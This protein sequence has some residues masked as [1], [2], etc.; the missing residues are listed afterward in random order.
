[1]EAEDYAV[2]AAEKVKEIQGEAADLLL[3]IRRAADIESQQIEEQRLDF[4]QR[5]VEK[6]KELQA[7]VI[8]VR[9]LTD[10]RVHKIEEEMLQ[11]QAQIEEEVLQKSAERREALKSVTEDVESLSALAD[12]EYQ[13][14]LEKEKEIHEETRKVMLDMDNQR[15]RKVEEIEQSCQMWVTAFNQRPGSCKILVTKSLT[16]NDPNW[17]FSKNVPK[18]DPVFSCIFCVSWHFNFI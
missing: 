6:V 5:H 8:R 7:E 2:Q 4:E 14:S 9:A 12:Q 17:R 10:E 16:K 1:M 18:T 3:H 15:W 13:K 11:E